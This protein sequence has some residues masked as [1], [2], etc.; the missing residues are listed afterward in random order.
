V[1]IREIRGKKEKSAR[2]KFQPQISQIS[3]D[4]CVLFKKFINRKKKN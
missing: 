4:F 3:T 2:E 1:Q